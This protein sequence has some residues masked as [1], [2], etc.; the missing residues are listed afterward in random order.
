MASGCTLS[1]GDMPALNLRVLERPV[2]PPET[3][4]D[5]TRFAASHRDQDRC[6]SCQIVGEFL[7]S[8]AVEFDADL[9][10]GVEDLRVDACSRLRAG[11][12]CGRLVAIGQGVEPGRGHL[13]PPGV[14]DACKENGLHA[15][16]SRGVL[17]H[18]MQLV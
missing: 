17:A 12:Y 2:H 1:R 3:R 9:A 16:P 4:Y 15:V 7:R 11:G 6:G 14:V 8:D 10:H 13:R 5:G 18:S